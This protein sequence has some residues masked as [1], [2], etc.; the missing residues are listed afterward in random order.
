MSGSMGRALPETY[1]ALSYPD[2]E[3]LV[4][5]ALHIAVTL[6]SHTACHLSHSTTLH[7]H[8][9]YGMYVQLFFFPFRV[10]CNVIHLRYST[11]SILLYF[12][13]LMHMGVHWTN[14]TETNKWFSH[15]DIYTFYIIKNRNSC[16]STTIS[17]C[18]FMH[19]TIILHI[20]RT[21]KRSE[22]I[23]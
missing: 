20:R 2:T 16:C 11:S 1:S 3:L 23:I 19:S 13:E 7:I 18:I 5:I 8:R 21:R 9:S 4:S 6:L 14:I 17:T 15:L 12:K 10:F 22:Y